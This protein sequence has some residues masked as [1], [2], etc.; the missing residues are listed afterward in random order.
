[1]N[2]QDITAPSA[3]EQNLRR[4]ILYGHIALMALILGFGGWS[5]ASSING[6]VIAPGSIV[7]ETSVKKVQHKDGGIVDKI[8]VKGGDYVDAGALLVRL[9]DTVTKAN[10]S[11]ISQQL[12]EIQARQARLETERDG[13]A[14]VSFPEDLLAQQSNGNVAKAIRGE[15]ILFDVRRKAFEALKAQSEQRAAQ[16]GEEI[17]G[18]RSQIKSKETEIRL[19]KAQLEKYYFL[20]AKGLITT[21]RILELERD[22]ASLDG[23]R[24]ELIAEVARSGAQVAEVLQ[25]RAQAEQD[26][27]TDIVEKLHEA[28]SQSAE[29]ADKKIAAEDQLRRINIRSPQSGYVHELNIHTV[30]GVIVPGE[31][32]MQIVP[33]GDQLLIEA[34]VAPT[35]V[36]QIY[37]N[38]AAV[39]RF[40][41]FDQRSTPEVQA[42]IATISADVTQDTTKQ[43]SYYIVRLRVDKG[44][45]ERLK[46][47]A[48]VPGMPAEVFLETGERSVL[49][50]FLKPLKDQSMRVFREE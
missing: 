32:V 43:Q 38:Q 16:L 20:R 41:A 4:H 15:R 28:Q 45:I 30:G 29:L 49:S 6:A 50:Y 42:H 7:V 34:H 2:V 11:I 35:D 14:D 39:V 31:T 37:P 22:A 48:L 3:V 33:R 12:S 23:Q 17:K 21:S 8:F 27:M 44:E 18:L 47:R 9:D 36:D 13:A 19:I 25:Q 46:N 1:M 24:G 40:S 10:L 26:R 5:V